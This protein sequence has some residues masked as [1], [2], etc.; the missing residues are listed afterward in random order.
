MGTT[1]VIKAGPEFE[2]LEVNSFDS[3]TLSS[4]V[5]VDNQLFKRTVDS[6][7]FQYALVGIALCLFYLGLLALSEICSFGVAYWTGAA[8]AILM[9]ALYSAKAL[10]SSGRAYLSAIGLAL[11][12][13]F[14][15][16]ILRLQDYSLLVGHA[17]QA[18]RKR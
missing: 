3:L 16:V 14:L 8:A 1:T 17:R 7:S 12:Y 5:A 10:R 6:I 13:A 15:F 9:I 4:P 2:I 11:V 18:K